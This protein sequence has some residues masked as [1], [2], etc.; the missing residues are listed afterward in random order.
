MHGGR[1]GGAQPFEIIILACADVDDVIPFGRR[2]V[3][4][5]DVAV[6]DDRRCRDILLN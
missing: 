2:V 1:N 3:G 4:K 5:G 6:L